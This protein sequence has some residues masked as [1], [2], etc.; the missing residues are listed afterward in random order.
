M[1]QHSAGLF[2]AKTSAYFYFYYFIFFFWLNGLKVF[3]EP[4]TS[5]N[6]FLTLGALHLSVPISQSLLSLTR[7]R[8]GQFREKKREKKHT[9]IIALAESELPCKECKIDNNRENKQEGVWLCR[10]TEKEPV[11][12][13]CWHRQRT[14]CHMQRIVQ[15]KRLAKIEWTEINI[16]DSYIN[17]SL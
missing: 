12:P 14:L 4:E 8:Q 17:V 11:I 7:Y 16:T 5:C 2:K 9:F 15:D 10:P 13:H 3:R 1:A 6:F